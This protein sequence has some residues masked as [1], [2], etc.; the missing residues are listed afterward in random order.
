MEL[1]PLMTEVTSRDLERRIHIAPQS[2]Q[3]SKVGIGSERQLRGTHD[4]CTAL[5]L[6][7]TC[8]IDA[9]DF[10]QEKVDG[11]SPNQLTYHIKSMTRLRSQ[12]FLLNG[13]DLHQ[14]CMV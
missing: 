1:V 7:Y 2:E 8:K 10:F 9:F 6:H 5:L 13:P 3:C 14:V 12:T 4:T 11:R